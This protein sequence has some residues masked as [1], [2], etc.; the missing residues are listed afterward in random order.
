MG[1]RR[2]RGW[3]RREQEELQVEQEE[4]IRWSRGRMRSRSSQWEV[5][6]V[7]EGHGARGAGVV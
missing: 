5:H 1:S 4:Q 3:S 7:V 6:G 2:S